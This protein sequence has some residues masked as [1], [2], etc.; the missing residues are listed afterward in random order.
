M[1][2]TKKFAIRLYVDGKQKRIKQVD[3]IEAAENWIDK[4]LG[5]APDGTDCLGRNRLSKVQG[6]LSEHG[7]VVTF[8]VSLPALSNRKFK[9]VVAQTKDLI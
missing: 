1:V 5:F 3:S 8:W 2:Y 6:R 4:A 9:A 7:K